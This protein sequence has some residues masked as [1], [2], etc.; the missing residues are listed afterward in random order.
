[1]KK[2]IIKTLGCKVNQY[3]SLA[4]RKLLIDAGFEHSFEDSE[5]VGLAIVNSCA[6]TKTSIAKGRRMFAAIGRENPNAKTVLLGCWAK[7]YPEEMKK[8]KADLIWEVGDHKKLV[9][10]IKKFFVNL[11]NTQLNNECEKLGSLKIVPPGEGERSRYFLKIQDG[12]EQFCSYC[13]IPYSRGKLSSRP[14]EEVLEEIRAA[15]EAGYREVVLCGIHLGLYGKEKNSA[16][17]NLGD[18][19][20]EI[21]KIKELGRVR[22]S[23]IEVVDVDDKL[24]ELMAKSSKIC[25]HLHFPLQSGSD[26]ILS[27]MNRPYTRNYFRKRV[28]KARE[29]MP[30]IAITTDVIVGFPGETEED[31]EQTVQLCLE[32]GF[33]NAHVFQFSAHEKTPAARMKD[34]IKKETKKT[35]AKKLRQISKE[36]E[37][38]YENKFKGQELSVIIGGAKEG[39]VLGKTEFHFDIIVSEDSL[40]NLK[41]FRIGELNKMIK[42]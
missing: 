12:C 39:Q 7:I 5:E 24:L 36:L 23:S 33:S 27:A 10:E 19:L 28:K 37:N 14:R 25:R 15:I 32:I 42:Q 35:R 16:T 34:Q 6:V 21:I 11:K 2:F 26:K 22:L 4:L 8:I 30:N 1:M 40:G 9:A 17:C 13:I 20:E 29:L 3:D 18:L 38:E 41:S 31:F